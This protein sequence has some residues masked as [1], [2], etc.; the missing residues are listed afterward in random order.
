MKLFRKINMP[1]DIF[2]EI[3][4]L[5]QEEERLIGID[6]DDPGRLFNEHD[7]ALRLTLCR[8]QLR[9]KRLEVV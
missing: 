9:K 1:K 3:W 5:E 7:A 2:T 4:Y 6:K 8:E